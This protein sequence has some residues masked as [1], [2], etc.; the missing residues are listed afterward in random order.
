MAKRHKREEKKPNFIY[1]FD[2][3][4]YSKEEQEFLFFRLV[5][6]LQRLDKQRKGDE[7]LCR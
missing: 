2:G 5:Q 4:E 1:K 7:L 6:L 3:K